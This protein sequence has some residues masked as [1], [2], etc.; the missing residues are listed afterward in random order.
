MSHGRADGGGLVGVNHSRLGPSVD[1]VVSL[2]L[3]E[4]LG[5][6]DWARVDVISEKALDMDSS[7][8]PA[9]WEDLVSS[10]EAGVSFRAGH[11]SSI[12]PLSSCSHLP[13]A[14]CLSRRH[15]GTQCSVA[16][17]PPL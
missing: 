1:L 16:G 9:S 3:R 15:S 17:G 5:R 7:D 13:R 2:P 12:L 8:W 11:C 14:P 4:H 6:P 10:V